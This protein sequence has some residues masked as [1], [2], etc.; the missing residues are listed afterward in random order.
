MKV[1]SLRDLRPVW[2]QSLLETATGTPGDL[3]SQG[4]S[5]YLEA[6]ADSALF[7]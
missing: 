7:K 3:C 6:K 2:R 5:M 4:N 1:N